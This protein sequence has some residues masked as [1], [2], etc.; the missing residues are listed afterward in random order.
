MFNLLCS[1]K[2]VENGKA[3]PSFVLLFSFFSIKSIHNYTTTNNRRRPMTAQ[4]RRHNQMSIIDGALLIPYHAAFAFI[5]LLSM[6][7][8]DYQLIMMVSLSWMEAVE[9]E[10]VKTDCGSRAHNSN[11]EKTLLIVNVVS[12]GSWILALPYFFHPI[13]PLSVTTTIH[14]STILKLR[15]RECLHPCDV[16]NVTFTKITNFR[17]FFSLKFRQTF[18]M[19]AL[20]SISSSSSLHACSKPS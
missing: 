18:G 15:L 6:Y 4:R 3:I 7:L 2:R 19:Q 14:T 1:G 12:L 11:S 13:P 17:L 10:N 20:K 5:H 16:S 9:A 8:D